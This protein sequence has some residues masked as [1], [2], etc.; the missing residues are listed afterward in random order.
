MEPKVAVLSRTKRNRSTL[1][2]YSTTSP[3]LGEEPYLREA[4]PPC[5]HWA[6]LQATFRD[7]QVVRQT[8]KGC[9]SN[10]GEEAA[11]T[12]RGGK[13][14]PGPEER[15]GNMACWEVQSLLPWNALPHIK[16]G[17]LSLLQASLAVSLDALFRIATSAHPTPQALYF[18]VALTPTKGLHA[19][20]P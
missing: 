6:P 5:G 14:Q 19:L 15:E 13:I 12:L 4:L 1:T 7:L 8:L 3:E 2:T 20:V 17:F 18:T 9:I 11:L 10:G 16:T